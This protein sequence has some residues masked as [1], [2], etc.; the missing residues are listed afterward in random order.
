MQP[1]AR[2]YFSTTAIATPFILDDPKG[3]ARAVAPA[4]QIKDTPNACGPSQT[5][6]SWFTWRSL[7]S[8]RSVA[9][10]PCAGDGFPGRT[11]PRSCGV[12]CSNFA[13]GYARSPHLRT[14]SDA[15]PV[16]RST[17]EASLTSTLFRS[18]TQQ[19]SR[20]RPKSPWASSSAWSTLPST[21][22]LCASGAPPAEGTARAAATDDNIV[23]PHGPPH[24]PFDSAREQSWS[25][26]AMMRS[27]GSQTGSPARVP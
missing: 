22:T 15:L 1:K 16:H 6:S 4:E 10:W 17:R 2:L 20:A 13:G 12:P 19:R 3:P 11:F 25:A 23:A 14:S 8:L 24:Q 7:P 18:C 26:N 27:R 9:C 5:S 21:R